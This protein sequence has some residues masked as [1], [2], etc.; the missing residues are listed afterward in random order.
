MTT[1]DAVF[2]SYRRA[3]SAGW[4]GR[5]SDRLAATFGAD[6]VFVDV[7]SIRPGTDFTQAI[8]EALAR[9]AAVVVV[10]GPAWTRVTDDTGRP[11]LQDPDD[12]VAV[13]VDRALSSGAA[14]LPVLVDGA[15]A[16]TAADLPD[17]LAA[18]AT[19]QALPVRA[20]TFDHDMDRLVAAIRAAMPADAPSPTALTPPADVPGGGGETSAPARRWI[21]PAVLAAVAALVVVGVVL[22]RAGDDDPVLTAPQDASP[23]AEEPAGPDDA[24]S[25]LPLLERAPN[26]GDSFQYVLSEVD[27]SVEADVYDLDWEETTD[28][29]LAELDAR[30]VHAICYLS[31]GSWE[32]FRSD[33]DAY[34]DE[35]LGEPLDEFPDE[36]WLDV[37]QQDVLVPLLE[38]RLDVCARKGFDSVEFDNTDGWVNDTGFDLTAADASAW[39]ET[40]AGLARR[41]GLAPGL[42]NSLEIA[43]EVE[44]LLDWLLV[45]ECIAHD[46]CD[47]VQPFVDAG[48]AVF[49]VA[50]DTPPEEACAHPV[51][52]VATVIVKPRDLGPEITSCR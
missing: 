20:D 19:R 50:Y 5:V 10:I 27:L 8:D 29:D 21:L 46:E 24:P 45:E 48:K 37:R 36:R 31:A 38:A 16:P 15:A 42:K 6:R 35:V 30:G 44:P 11:R 52:D 49:V 32:E 9:A 39:I 47:L 28:E 4:A 25:P 7:A 13:E 34:P 17:G 40:L 43:P 18:L 51:N 41:R 3:D 2:I 22:S 26:P 12:L 33:A 14:V 1:R 23:T